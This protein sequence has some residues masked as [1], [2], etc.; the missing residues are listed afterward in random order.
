MIHDFKPIT[1]EIT[2]IN[3][4]PTVRVD[5]V[6]VPVV[7]FNHSY[8]T[9]DAYFEGEHNYLLK[10]ID[11]N[12][13][14]FIGHEKTGMESEEPDVTCI[15]CGSGDLEIAYFIDDEEPYF[16]SKRCLSCGH[17]VTEGNGVRKATQADLDR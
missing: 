7:E 5:G 8:I 2:D 1:I 17:E 6:K 12:K 3:K 10:Y 9:K 15:K 16:K 4:P 14:C 13:V 11:G